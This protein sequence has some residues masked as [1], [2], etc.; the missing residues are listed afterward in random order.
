MA[1][2]DVLER[3]PVLEHVDSLGARLISTLQEVLDSHGRGHMTGSGSIFQMH[4]TDAPP[5]NRREILAGDH[6]LLSAVL[7]GMCAHGILWPPVH[8]GVVAHGH[9]ESDIDRSAAALDTVLEMA[10]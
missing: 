4:F 7:L 3:E 1:V 5:R 6:E 10:S 2:L 9:T 8:P